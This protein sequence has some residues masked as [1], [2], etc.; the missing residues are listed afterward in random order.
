MYIIQVMLQPITGLSSL[1][2]TS[3]VKWAMDVMSLGGNLWVTPVKRWW[4]QGWVKVWPSMSE[5]CGCHPNP[6]GEIAYGHHNQVENGEVATHMGDTIVD[7]DVGP[8]CRDPHLSHIYGMKCV[9]RCE[10]PFKEWFHPKP[11]WWDGLQPPW[12]GGGWRS[13]RANERPPF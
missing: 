11:A 4:F 12:P 3:R 9:V 13:G 7:T 2:H 1:V 6:P 8:R 5:R 10:Y